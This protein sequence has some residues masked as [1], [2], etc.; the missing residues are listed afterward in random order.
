MTHVPWLLLPRDGPNSLDAVL[1]R[2]SRFQSHHKPTKNHKK[3]THSRTR[4]RFLP[5][6]TLRV[7]CLRFPRRWKNARREL[8][9]NI[10]NGATDTTNNRASKACTSKLAFL[11]QQTFAQGHYESFDWSRNTQLNQSQ[12]IVRRALTPPSP[13]ATCKIMQTKLLFGNEEGGKRLARD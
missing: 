4:N 12:S 13:L 7:D 6:S 3:R 10:A 1:L 5:R 11:V 2:F 9:E 8:R